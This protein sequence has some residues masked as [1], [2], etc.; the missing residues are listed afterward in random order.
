MKQI[1]CRILVLL[2]VVAAIL[3]LS[4]CN[5]FIEQE[6]TF[7]D[8]VV[9]NFD[10]EVVYGSELDFSGLEIEATTGDDV[11]YIPVNSSM[12]VSGDTKTVGAQE[13][14][15]EYGGF[16]WTLAYEVFYKVEH[17]VDGLV[18]DSQ[19]VSSRDEILFVK[20]PEKNGSI[21]LGW[22]ED[23]PETLTGNIRREAVFVDNI[24]LPKLSATYGDTLGDITLPTVSGGKWHWQDSEET[25]VGNAG[26]N[27][28]KLVYV[29]DDTTKG[30][31]TFDV[32]VEVAKK[33]VDIKVL[34]EVFEYNGKV[35]T[36]RYELSEDVPV[37][38]IICF[39]DIKGTEIGEYSY[40]IRIFNDNYEGQYSG[41]FEIKPI[42]ITIT[43]LLHDATDDSYKSNVII[44]YGNS[45]PTYKVVI[46]DK[47]GNEYKLD[48]DLTVS[49]PVLL[50]AG[51]YEITT[52]FDDAHYTTKI[53]GA[54]LTV[55]SVDLDPG[56]P[57]LIGA[58]NV[59]FGDKLSEILFEEH[60]LG[61]WKWDLSGG[62]TVGNAGKNT[63]VAVFVPKDSSYNEFRYD[64]ELTVNRKQLT[65]DITSSRTFVFDG[66]EYG[67]TYDVI[68]P[69]S[70]EVVSGLKVLGNQKFVNAGTH[71]IT[72]EFE[73]KNYQAIENT[74][75]FTIAQATIEK[76][77]SFIVDDVWFQGITLSDIPL[78]KGY[79]WN[80]PG[81]QIGEPGGYSYGA[82]FYPEDQNY[83]TVSGSLAIVLDKATPSLTTDKT[84]YGGI[85][86][87]V[88]EHKL[89]GII[90]HNSNSDMRNNVEY[91]ISGTD[92]KIAGLTNAGTYNIDVVVP[93]SNKYK[94]VKTSVVVVVNKANPS[95]DR[96][97]IDGWTFGSEADE[98]ISGSKQVEI[99]GFNYYTEECGQYTKLDG[100]PTNAG[101]YYVSAYSL[102][103]EN[104][105]A[106]ESDYRQF[107]IAKFVVTRPTLAHDVYTGGTLSASVPAST[108]YKVA[109][110]GN[111]ARM[112]AGTYEVV[113][114]LLDSDN[115]IWNNG[116][117]LT[118][119]ISYVIDKATINLSAIAGS[120]SFIYDN[121]FDFVSEKTYTT[122]H[123][124]N[125]G[126]VVYLYATI[127]NPTVFTAT[128]PE[129]VGTY[130]VKAVI[131]ADEANNW[132]AVE[133][134][135]FRFEI[136][137][138][139]ISVPEL[140]ETTSVFNG[141]VF[142][143]TAPE[144]KEIY[145]IEYEN[146]N[147]INKGEYRVTFT[148]TNSNYK[149]EDGAN[150]ERTYTITAATPEIYDVVSGGWTFGTPITHSASAKVTADGHEDYLINVENA[151]RVVYYNINN[152]NSPISKPSDAGT[153]YVRFVV[154]ADN[155]N[156]NWN[157]VSSDYIEFTIEQFALD[158]PELVGT[159]VY[160]FTGS[161]IPL[162]VK[163][164]ETHKVHYSVSGNVKKNV[165]SYT[166]VYSLE[167]S[168]Y[169]WKDETTADKTIDYTIEQAGS[170]VTDFA[171]IGWTF[172]DS[173]NAIG[174]TAKTSTGYAISEKHV[175]ISFREVD[176]DTWTTI[177]P[178]KWAT[179]GPHYAGD[180]YVKVS[181]GS[182]ENN[183]W[184]ISESAEILLNIAKD[185][186][187]MSG[188]SWN[189]TSPFT[190]NDSDHTVSVTGTLPSGVTV[191]EY[192]G[193]V[194]EN[195]GTYTANVKFSYDSDNY[196]EPTLAS[197][198]WT[199]DPQI[200]NKP[201]ADTTEFVYNTTEQKYVLATHNGYK[202]S[203][204]LQTN[205][206]TYEVVVTLN[207]TE[208]IK[209]Y[210][211]D[212]ETYT[213][214]TYDFVISPKALETAFVTLTNTLEYN[215]T[216]QTQN[217]LVKFGSEVLVLDEDYSITGDVQTNAGE[218][219]ELTVTAKAD[220][221]YTG[222]VVISYTVARK[223]I[224]KPSAATGLAFNN[225][226]LDS[227]I[228]TIEG[229]WTVVDTADAA[230]VSGVTPAGDYKV[231][232]T[233]NSNY[234]WND[235]STTPLELPYKIDK[236]TIKLTN[237]TAQYPEGKTS[238]TFNDTIAYKATSDK[239]F[240]ESEIKY[241][242]SATLNGTYTEDFIF[243]R[244]TTYY[245]KAQ[246]NADDNWY[247][248]STAPVQF[249]IN[250]M[251]VS[252]PSVNAIP[253][254]ANGTTYKLVDILNNFDSS[255]MSFAEGS[256]TSS[257]V[258]GSFNAKVVLDS[259]YVWESTFD[260]NISWS[261]S[262]APASII[263]EN[264]T[265]NKDYREAGYSIYD[266]VS[267]ITGNHSEVDPD[268]SIKT[269]GDANTYTVTVTLAESDNYFA[270]ESKDITIIIN[271]I[272]TP[273]V[274]RGL[275]AT[276]G[277]LLSSVSLDA[278][279]QYG[280]WEWIET[281]GTT[282]DTVGE[283]TFKAKFT[284]YTNDSGTSNYKAISE[285]P[286]TVTVGQKGIFVPY[287][288]AGQTFTYKLHDD[289]KNH[290][291]NLTIPTLVMG[292]EAVNV[293]RI[294][295][296]T[297][298]TATTH[299][300]TVILINGN[301]KWD[302]GAE[303]TVRTFTYT[304]DPYKITIPKVEDKPYADG[305]DINSGLGN[306]V[307]GEYTV[308]S[309]PTG[310]TAGITL[311]VIL[312]LVDSSNTEWYNFYNVTNEV[313]Y[314]D[315]SEYVKI[316][317]K[318]A[319]ATNEWV[320]GKE[321]AIDAEM[322]YGTATVDRPEVLYGGVRMEYK[323][324]TATLWIE[325]PEDGN[326][327][328]DLPV[329]EYHI[330]F[331]STDTSA[332]EKTE[333]L[334]F[335]I[336]PAPATITVTNGLGTGG[337]YLVG[338]YDLS[339]ISATATAN[340][341][342]A[343]IDVDIYLNGEKVE[344]LGKVYTVGTYEV[345]FKLAN[346]NYSAAEQSVTVKITK[347][348]L[349][350]PTI[351]DLDYKEVTENQKP[352][353]ALDFDESLVEITN[354][355]GI[356]V[357][358]GGYTVIIKIT[359][360]AYAKY[361][362]NTVNKPANA[363]ISGDTVTITYNIKKVTNSFT[364]ADG[365]N[366]DEP[367]YVENWTY[368]NE[369]NSPVGITGSAFGEV[370]YQYYK[371]NT[372]TGKYEPVGIEDVK[373][374]GDY[375]VVAY[376][377]AN[378][379]NYDRIESLPAYFEITV[380]E[381]TPPTFSLPE[382]LDKFVFEED[383]VHNPNVTESADRKYYS[384]TFGNAGNDDAGTYSVIVNIKDEHKGSV[385]W[386]A[387]AV[388]EYEYI[389]DKA[390]VSIPELTNSTVYNGNP[391]W[392]TYNDDASVTLNRYS[393]AEIAEAKVSATKAGDIG[394]VIF[395]L[396]DPDNYR[397]ENDLT[398]ENGLT[399]TEENT[400]VTFTVTPAPVN[401]PVVSASRVFNNNAQTSGWVTELNKWFVDDNGVTESGV[402]PVGDYTATITLNG[403][404]KWNAI[405][406]GVT[407]VTFD[408]D[409]AQ[410]AYV[411]YSITAKSFTDSDITVSHN[412]TGLTYGDALDGKKVTVMFGTTELEE[413]TDFVVVFGGKST[414]VGA[415]GY[416]TV[417]IIACENGNYTGDKAGEDFTI[418]TA[419]AKFETINNS[420]WNNKQ[421]GSVNAT[422]PS[423]TVFLANNTSVVV[424]D[425]SIRVYY[426]LK[427]DVAVATFS[428]E[429]DPWTAAGWTLWTAE[430]YPSAVGKYDIAVVV[431]ADE[432]SNYNTETEYSETFEIEI[433]KANTSIDGV[434]ANLEST[435]GSYTGPKTKAELLSGVSVKREDGTVVVTPSI[436][437]DFV[438]H[439]AGTA[440]DGE[441]IGSVAGT[442]TITYSYA[443]DDSHNAATVVKRV[444]T[445]DKATSTISGVTNNQ[446]INVEAYD[447]HNHLPTVTINGNTATPDIAYTA[448]VGYVCTS[449][450]NGK[451]AGTYV[452]TY[453]FAGDNNYKSMSDVVVTL[454]IKQVEQVVTESTITKAETIIYGNNALDVI[455]LP[456]GVTG[457]EWKLYSHT[458]V[459]VTDETT[460]GNA[461]SEGKYNVFYARFE[462]T[463]VNY[464]STDFIEVKISVG[465][466]TPAYTYTTDLERVYG[467]SGWNAI[468]VVTIKGVNGETL[469]T[470]NCN[471]EITGFGKYTFTY[472]YESLDSNYESREIALTVNVSKNTTGG[473]LDE[474]G[475]TNVGGEYGTTIT[476]PTIKVKVGVVEIKS[477]ITTY[478]AKANADGT[479]P[480]ADS[481]AWT[482]TKP[483][484][485][486][487][488]YVKVSVDETSDYDAFEII[489]TK[490]FEITTKYVTAPNWLNGTQPQYTFGDTFTAP[491]PTDSADSAY[492]TVT[493]LKDG[494]AAGTYT[495]VVTLKSEHGSNIAW[496][497]GTSVNANYQVELSYVINKAL[498]GVPTVGDLTFNNKTRIPT[499]TVD[500]SIISVTN[501]G[502]KDVGKYNV[503]LVLDTTNHE[504]DRATLPDNATIGEDGQTATITYN[505]NP[506]DITS[507]DV[508]R[509]HDYK[510]LTYIGVAYGNLLKVS[511]GV[512]D[513]V[514]GEDYTVSITRNDV[515]EDSVTNAGNYVLL[516]TGNGN[517]T[518][519]YRVR[520]TIAKA[521]AEISGI[522][523]GDY[524]TDESI[525]YIGREI[526]LESI[527]NMN[528]A[529]VTI[530][531]NVMSNPS[532]SYS[533]QYSRFGS[534]NKTTT[535]KILNAGTYV[536]TISL[537]SE[538]YY[539]TLTG[540]QIQVARVK[541]DDVLNNRLGDTATTIYYEGLLASLVNDSSLTW[542]ITTDFSAGTAKFVAI[543][544]EGN[545][546]YIGGTFTVTKNMKFF[547]VARVGGMTGTPYGTVEA[548][549][550]A[551]SGT[552]TTVW[553]MP[554]A[555]LTAQIPSGY[556][557]AE[558]AITITGNAT[559]GTG[560]TLILPHGSSET[561]RNTDG[562]NNS[563]TLQVVVSQHAIKDSNKCVTKV[564]LEGTITVNGTLE[565]NG[566]MS[567][568]A[569]GSNLSGGTS[570]NF[571]ELV[572]RG[573]AQII[574]NG[575]I[576]ASGYI[577]ADYQGHV[578]T[579]DHPSIQINSG[580]TIYQP[581][582]IRDYMSGNYFAAVG[583]NSTNAL[584]T[585]Q[586]PSEDLGMLPFNEFTFYNV[587]PF[588]K[589]NYGGTMW[590]WA[591]LDTGTLNLG[592]TTLG[593]ANHTEMVF[594]G[595]AG[596]GFIQ[597]NTGS[598][599]TSQIDSETEICT[600]D[601]YGGMSIGKFELKLDLVIAN[602]NAS[603]EKAY[604][605]LCWAYDITLH[606]GTYNL[607]TQKLKL[608]W[609]S[610]LTVAEDATLNAGGSIQ[611][612]DEN[613]YNNLRNA[614]NTCT[615]GPNKVL[616][617]GRI[618]MKN[619]EP[620]FDKYGKLIVNGTLKATSI[621]GKVCSDNPG[622]S[623]TI[624]TS[625]P[626]ITYEAATFTAAGIKEISNCVLNDIFVITKNVCLNEG[627]DTVI[628][629]DR[630]L[631]YNGEKWVYG[632]KLDTD[633]GDDIVISTDAVAGSEYTVPNLS[634]YNPERPYYTFDG[635][636]LDS[637]LSI[638]Y[639]GSQKIPSDYVVN[640]YANWS[641]TNYDIVYDSVIDGEY[642]KPTLPENGSFNIESGNIT[643]P[644]VTADGLTL[645]GIFLD[646]DCT[647]PVATISSTE[648][649]EYLVDAEF[650]DGKVVVF[651]YKWTKETKYSITF[652]Q[653]VSNV[654]TL[655][656]NIDDV[657]DKIPTYDLYDHSENNNNEEFHYEFR[658]WQVVI[659]GSAITD[660]EGNIIYVKTMAEVQALMTKD[661][662]TSV[663]L[664]ANWEIKYKLMIKSQSSIDR[665]ETYWLNADQLNE[666][667]RYLANDAM[668]LY[669]YDANATH[670]FDGWDVKN[671]TADKFNA[672]KELTVTAQWLPKVKITVNI[673][674][675]ENSK[676]DSGTNTNVKYTFKVYD[677][678]VTDVSG[679]K[680]YY[681]S[682]IIDEL[683]S[684]TI[685]YYVIPG[686]K[687]I[688]SDPSGS[689][690]SK[691]PTIL[692]TAG[693]DIQYD[694]ESEKGTKT[695]SGGGGCLVEGTLIT[696]ADGTL[697]PIEELRMDDEILILN[698]ETGKYESG[699]VWFIVHGELPRENREI[700]TLTFS[701][702]TEI[703]IAHEHA[704]FDATVSKY[705]YL[706]TMNATEYLGHEFLNSVLVNGEYVVSKVT[707]VDVN[708]SVEYVKVYSPISEMYLNVVANG[709]L[710]ATASLFDLNELINIYDYDS[711]GKYIE[712]TR[713]ADLE[714]YGEYTYEEFAHL[715]SKNEFDT[716]PLRYLKV[717][718]EKGLI[719]R[720]D[721]ETLIKT[722]V[723]L[724]YM[725]APN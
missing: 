531:G 338:G 137:K 581:L 646:E 657:W 447:G 277:D 77:F 44:D 327:P 85:T 208:T 457:G 633:W 533:Y 587:Q 170:S 635:W 209:N 709:M 388:T 284:P 566:V 241:L 20:D 400:K 29:F 719:T 37:E 701:D 279:K 250:Q 310:T 487:K 52:A 153:Y 568:G 655:P 557:S 372:A 228:Y 363:S 618:W 12:I 45:F 645:L 65:F 73:D 490:S 612:Y 631:F 580:G 621:G 14:E 117:K 261:V 556:S 66:K 365:Y 598:Y 575:V 345:V 104:Y 64:V 339:K 649:L 138:K 140:S 351:G 390:P 90:T 194:E 625:V 294:E 377:E 636:Y 24:T 467:E 673:T 698:H 320:N 106:A 316:T 258:A 95:I 197:L 592:I 203:G 212:D 111:P 623:I 555:N 670:Y 710:T 70:R 204:N 130:L 654:V 652:D 546:N 211:W 601:F 254:Y 662:T 40:T 510:N 450:E 313:V 473:T 516:V 624:T 272:D 366:A 353:V 227:G 97:A 290:T 549:L 426:K 303:G 177:S 157:T 127:D 349:S 87:N 129:N 25:S 578:P 259:N 563:G 238:W 677:S 223:P 150:G 378:G 376:V 501:V 370:E 35:N 249:K 668:L 504:W 700:L 152:K 651:Y 139:P 429:E 165:G 224:S 424:E 676:V 239:T 502:G 161:D 124:T 704:L 39:G 335:E 114:E 411:T 51:T 175:S 172:N 691:L 495:Y 535:D 404:Y 432:E 98:P 71:S 367:L 714:K 678:S 99:A 263:I 724:G 352:D 27:V 257:G 428:V 357:V 43:V 110:N 486:G 115:Y 398:V 156:G 146:K 526:S 693:K 604:F 448:P 692:E 17:I 119:K 218:S 169:K 256:V 260:G 522:T 215:E 30:E 451:T 245:V 255:I 232:V 537:D 385:E 220:S 213:A 706:S 656:E 639:T 589:I 613:D 296:L 547:T 216:A 69:N 62:D 541:A 171:V 644:A 274:I 174:Y 622:A 112:N 595:K 266:I 626:V 620:T 32:D 666:A 476:Y 508:T 667:S 681:N 559:V 285:K 292:D 439:V 520:F 122:A 413:G 58:E 84:V 506:L 298:S 68:D 230:T 603:S 331:T 386:V 482:T 301:Y 247:A 356:N 103:T 63:F 53:E 167:N 572:I 16:S 721:V 141:D 607:G 205:A 359:A 419:T 403:N 155:A 291:P 534:N 683:E 278:Y 509:D 83:A 262:K 293:Y 360:D 15:I 675:Q 235:G 346:Y 133:T 571:A 548:A 648:L 602:V 248:A 79:K 591:N 606:N 176:S 305:A 471:S 364:Y 147:S 430:N 10:R 128:V 354:N 539:G 484:T 3:G 306:G 538:N 134:A 118:T 355:G 717:G 397:W 459:V 183:N 105:H 318:I 514:F 637:G 81:I 2:V 523:I 494:T 634:D 527:V 297:N 116:D 435:Y 113:L 472:S 344:S 375:Q 180:Y 498:V 410:I 561:D 286:L 193:N 720:E 584:G 475:W 88:T 369:A 182:D 690:V 503:V 712:E 125:F 610:K 276:Y 440:W 406:E 322:T 658:G 564:I 22:S 642:E 478:Y 199:I 553:I 392:G 333:T 321:P 405:P 493:K 309:D 660:D 665:D 443:G 6:P 694:V 551:A 423:P 609:G 7:Y 34:D 340:V 121:A 431:E 416:Y 713:I 672:N 342:G 312:K 162:T 229:Q 702:G 492:Y 512:T 350:V 96:P 407:N 158:I 226:T 347:A 469:K 371:K 638:S 396:N 273:D 283:R 190:F 101:I 23:M 529:I 219:Y 109:E 461:T 91:Y 185:D 454:N 308:E 659:N 455:S 532:F 438:P 358:D 206:G 189:Y 13:L 684:K 593:G 682:G 579:D 632:V 380:R 480:A 674:C 421:F 108:L 47:N 696:M 78:P 445:I 399:G 200:V 36:V 653:N 368:D 554:L 414:T 669:N 225:G 19:L 680:E 460:V 524:G 222:S 188:V 76:D 179:E 489:S 570:G 550:Q 59:V 252:V 383:A 616:V 707:L 142:C 163:E 362:W 240:V 271:P 136:T 192:T 715:F 685:Y 214:K 86:Y 567:G 511:L 55:N 120:S 160:T 268:Y 671:I 42:E 569:A 18:Y 718:V 558:G 237:L 389:V 466:A 402:T 446:V 332:T 722:C 196:N 270:A 145:T 80:N 154:S 395:Q 401:A 409:N 264:A 521:K 614:I 686:D 481:D 74:F 311:T 582:I 577:T 330:R 201:K 343:E 50:K 94:S 207:N 468:P 452:L 617:Y 711:D 267:G 102:A 513:L 149:W 518:G 233:L 166:A 600:V 253:E 323:L 178:S 28:F 474:S 449:P 519:S 56:V 585:T 483:T 477:G 574:C 159:G 597:L 540:I 500:E 434:G 441:T 515:E 565:I 725:E 93:E 315:N 576:R 393:V 679:A 594:V 181:I 499:V 412:Y 373:H 425:A 374:A 629:S 496:A 287:V 415:A 173:A 280:T 131:Y 470:I 723:A 265:F 75:T 244:A 588:M 8:L 334:D 60:Q 107:E 326:L 236:A 31:L 57:G 663:T 688:F 427:T 590:S 608:M 221:N 619:N 599:M 325:I 251:P 497:K 123:V 361:E 242:Y 336:T 184:A 505:I 697:K 307:E 456:T 444:I 329:G 54:T 643:P 488:W 705:V 687:Y 387:N 615:N 168:N 703:K 528:S 11:K 132:K 217:V 21:F 243:D 67:L 164:T 210:I 198:E 269:F 281:S 627:E 433:L 641:P 195:A 596:T 542:D 525:K 716:C 48:T 300:V 302:D 231:T 699:K 317:Y 304:I 1:L 144:N 530:D 661:V 299:T 650:G 186:Y 695:N 288:T 234:K 485:V 382:G 341:G 191:K 560:V 324:K 33:H 420:N 408:K 586:S 100:V 417:T 328:A 289:D 148:I 49:K 5:I 611:I 394:Y 507:N 202:I 143:P 82:T 453:S 379:N 640:V 282:V 462:S 422:A 463:D 275:E 573:D 491:E 41:S 708:V 437:I 464:A 9:N 630:P 465:K 151:V 187:D 135:P 418:A 517:Y 46:T 544:P 628:K 689:D 246:V 295:G 319:T 72:L 536:L 348:P 552:T 126:E 545:P 384:Y 647:I 442:Y 605:P 562:E 61:Y 381:I 436:K 543:V 89:S 583:H 26:T 314:G 4:S 391:I 92:E 38:D 664:R 479:A 337:I 458:Y